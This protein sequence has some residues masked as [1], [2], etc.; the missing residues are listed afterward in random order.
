MG[1]QYTW[2]KR[3]IR[4]RPDVVYGVCKAIDLKSGV[5]NVPWRSA[6]GLSAR[7]ADTHQVAAFVQVRE[8]H[9]ETVSYVE[10]SLR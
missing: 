8:I 5:I 9:R 4:R 3:M 10:S 2:A 7:L 6:T 1:M